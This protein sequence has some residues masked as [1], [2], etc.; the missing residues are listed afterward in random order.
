M[1]PSRCCFSDVAFP[2]LSITYGTNGSG[3]VHFPRVFDATARE[4]LQVA[5]TYVKLH[6]GRQ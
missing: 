2:V 3:F 4:A 6:Q 5:L 1:P